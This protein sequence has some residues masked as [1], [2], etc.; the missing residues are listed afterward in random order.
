MTKRSSRRPALSPQAEAEHAARKERES[1]A[2][3][4]NL[5]KRKAQARQRRE[6]EEAAAAAKAAAKAE[7]A[8]S[9]SPS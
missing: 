4:E 2:L 8:K 9:G 6:E 7:A 5:I 1:E 3:R